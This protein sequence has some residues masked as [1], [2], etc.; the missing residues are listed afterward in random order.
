MQ[1]LSLNNAR[2]ADMNLQSS[3]RSFTEVLRSIVVMTL[4]ASVFMPLVSGAFTPAYANKYPIT[5][6]PTQNAARKDITI[7]KGI[8]VASE[9]A[10]VDLNLRN[11]SIADILQLLAQQGNFNIIVDNS[12]EG[13]MTIDV[14][15]ITVNKAL[16]YIMTMGGLSYTQDG[17]TIVVSDRE[18]ANERSL[19]AKIFKVIPVKY[20]DAGQIAARLN[21]TVFA[22]QK[23]GLNNFAVASFDPNTNSLLLIAT[24]RD[25]AFVEEVLTQLDI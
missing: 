6:M 24:E 10:T 15:N 16:E 5:V 9:S 12:V 2:Q 17:R 7:L 23:P 18:T 22:P 14:R 1:F 21:Q 20:K 3:P 4:I 25:I 19:N 8:K 11:T 13:E